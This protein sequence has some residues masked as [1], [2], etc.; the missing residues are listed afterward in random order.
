MALTSTTRSG[1]KKVGPT[2][3]GQFFKA[4]QALLEEALAPL[5]DHVA[6]SVEALGDLV[7]TQALGCQEYDLGSE[8]ISIRQRIFPGSGLEGRTFFWSQL[9]RVRG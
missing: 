2:G 7:V 4:G 6:T 5:A 8:H 3:A 9:D 1:G